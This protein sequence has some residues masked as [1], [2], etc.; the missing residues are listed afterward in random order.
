MKFAN[1][2]INIGVK[3]INSKYI[4]AF[5]IFVTGIGVLLYN[6][7]IQYFQ[8]SLIESFGIDMLGEGSGSESNILKIFS[9]FFD[10]KCLSKLLFLIVL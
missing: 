1:S 6:M 7:Y 9:S 4:V 5:I 2:K 10:N 8:T 3:S